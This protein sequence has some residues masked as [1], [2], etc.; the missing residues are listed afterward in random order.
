MVESPEYEVKIEHYRGE[1]I[2][3]EVSIIRKYYNHKM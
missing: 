1:K 3:Y 2:K